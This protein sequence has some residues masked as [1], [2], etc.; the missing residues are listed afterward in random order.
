MKCKLALSIILTAI[1]GCADLSSNANE[2][3]DVT[4]AIQVSHDYL[5]DTRHYDNVIN[6]TKAFYRIKAPFNQLKNQSTLVNSSNWQQVF[7]NVAE[8][9]NERSKSGLEEIISR[10]CWALKD[11]AVVVNQYGAFRGVDTLNNLSACVSK[12]LGPE[13]PLFVYA[14]VDDKKLEDYFMM[15]T[16][17]GNYSNQEYRCKLINEGYVFKNKPIC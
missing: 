6:D 3:Y 17:K 8:F 12:R 10:T 15:V 9:K 5:L 1:A 16:Y 14:W 13:Y 4:N 11:D 7:I 2:Q